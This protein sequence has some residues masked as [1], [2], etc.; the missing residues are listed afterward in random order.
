[1]AHEFYNTS[2]PEAFRTGRLRLRLP[3]AEEEFDTATRGTLDFLGVNY[4]FRMFV[5]LSPL[6]LTAPSL[7]WEDRSGHGLSEMGWESFPRGLSEALATASLAGVPL[8]VTEN[9]TAESDDGRKVAY[10]EE[11]LRI[12]RRAVREGSD[13]R[14]Y[15]WWSLM[16]NYEWLEGLRP[17]FGLYRTDR[18]TLARSA[19]SAALAYAR[20]IA[21]HPD[22]GGSLGP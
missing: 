5:S 10:M 12:L 16:D 6:R 17:R 4:Y 11:H 14:G 1:M 13:V 2:L 18:E 21:A 22:P 8:V 7:A 9:G 19:T 20:W 15:F 3:F